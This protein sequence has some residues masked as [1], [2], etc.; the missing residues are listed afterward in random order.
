[1]NIKTKSIINILV[2]SSIIFLCSSFWDKLEIPFK[3]HQSVGVLSEL[4][5]NNLNDTIRYV[6][7][8]T[9]PLLYYF[10]FISK[11]F[12]KKIIKINDL[13]ANHKKKEDN[14]NFTDIKFVFLFLLIL[15]IF[16]FLSLQTPSRDNLDPLHDGDYLTPFINYFSYKK[17]WE[18]SFTVHGGSDL[19]YPI[20]AWKIF[21]MQTIGTFK[22]FKYV[23]VLLLKILSILFVFYISK[24]SKLD[25]RYKIILFTMLS[26]A[27]LSFSSYNAYSYLNIRDLYAF[28]FFIFFI[29]CF[30]K[31]E[32]ILLNLLISITTILTLLM[33]I[34][35]GIYLLIILIFYQIYLIYC[36]NFK[37]FFQILFFLLLSS[38]VVFLIFGKAEIL[39][40]LF[41]LEHMIFNIDKIHG[42][43][44]PQPFY[45]MGEHPDGSRATKVIMFQLISGIILISIVFF[46]NTYFKL[47]EKLFFLFFYLY[48]LIA[49][50]NALGRSDGP[51]MM[52]SSD[53][54]S[55]ILCFFILH[56][57]MYLYKKNNILKLDKKRST[58]LSILI[59]CIV[60]L[61]NTNFD[62]LINFKERFAKSISTPDVEYLSEER[63][64]I[65]NLLK[66][67]VK[68]ETCI[69]NFTGDLIIP[70]LIKKPTC[71][72][73]FSS[74][75]AS[76]YKI[77]KD[78][79]NQLKNKNVKYIYYASP[80]YLVDD[81][82]TSERLK[83]VNKFI[84]D[85][86]N[87]VF[88]TNGYS[89]V[90]FKD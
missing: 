5:Y 35:I 54:Q 43:K 14:F 42:L 33:H 22:L 55:I 2:L 1:M 21:G 11:N 6:I 48:C 74:W 34:D 31:E 30:L 12:K 38:L 82:A 63:I 32:R 76:G 75:L 7:F 60:T 49:F 84:K 4:K 52:Q 51:H 73:Y 19:F 44:F 47:N 56:L 17:F 64:S 81:I 20:I 66:K 68:N 85:N 24:L 86:Y 50:K 61:F 90:I 70:Y 67:N 10:F 25:K 58:I 72:K 18:G 65:I 62:N 8:L 83:H 39:S 3:Y 26:L 57:F 59:I 28:V 89:L 16:E 46:K 53:W 71:T 27:I 37:D 9:L 45:S 23:L 40:F 29:Q 80:A 69:Q 78:Y 79:I 41:H 87:V 13:F 36:K 15:V 77:E 88:D